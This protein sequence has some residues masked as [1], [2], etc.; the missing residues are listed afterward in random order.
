MQLMTLFLFLPVA[1]MA[2]ADLKGGGGSGVATPLQNAP[3]PI[4]AAVSSEPA[5]KPH[6][7]QAVVKPEVLHLFECLLLVLYCVEK[8]ASGN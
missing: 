6:S 1:T 2:G 3:S 7:R 8:A 4:C 5:V